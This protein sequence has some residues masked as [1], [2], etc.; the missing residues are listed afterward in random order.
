MGVKASSKQNTS[1]N[2]NFS[3]EQL[4]KVN[5]VYLGVIITKDGFCVKD[6]H[7]RISKA[8]LSMCWKTWKNIKYITD[9]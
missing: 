4:E 3:N 7:N 5:F 8:S 6:N 1:L 9:N 2:I